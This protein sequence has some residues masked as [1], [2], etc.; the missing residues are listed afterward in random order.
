MGIDFQKPEQLYLQIINDIKEKISSGELKVGQQLASHNE[1]TEIYGVSLITVRR[2][3]SELVKE[4]VL[5]S[6]MGK[7]TFVLEKKISIEI[8]DRKTIG[9]VLKD[10]DDPFFSLIARSIEEKAS[11]SAINLLLSSTRGSSIKEEIQ[12]QFFRRIGVNGLIIAS[13]NYTHRATQ[14]IR[15]IH[16]EGFPYVMVSYVEDDDIYYVGVDHEYGAFIATEHL[17]K[18]GH[19]KVAYICGQ[20]GNVLCSLRQKGFLEALGQYDKPFTKDLLIERK[21]QS[22]QWNHYKVGYE[23]GSYFPEMKNKPDAFFIYNDL[24]ALG[25]QQ[26]ILDQ[27]YK[28]PEDVAI[29]GFDNIEADVHA[30]VPLTTVNQPTKEIGKLAFKIVEKK[31]NGIPAEVRS[32][33]RPNLIVRNSCG[34]TRN[35]IVSKEYE[36][37][38]IGTL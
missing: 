37:Q 38:T 34:G 26:S 28:V 16:N 23:I 18:L 12:I 5:Y 13:A 31:I 7:G 29:V 2:A 21:S 25:F 33:L 24:C 11:K 17:I 6:R 22:G 20:E 27:G 10:L 8:T 32:I 36:S 1:L 30:R 35:N 14:K 4:K 15:K 3:L 19:K 9:L